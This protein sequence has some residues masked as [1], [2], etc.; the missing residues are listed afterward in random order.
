LTIRWHDQLRV[1]HAEGQGSLKLAAVEL[2]RTL[3]E[4]A[5]Y[6]AREREPHW[7]VYDLYKTGQLFNSQV[8]PAAA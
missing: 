1:V 7:Y 3:F 5:E 6:L 8:C 4:S 2:G